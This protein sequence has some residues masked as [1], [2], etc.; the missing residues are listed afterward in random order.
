[1]LFS[2][3][4]L[5]LV[6][7][8]LVSLTLAAEPAM[9]KAKYTIKCGHSGAPDSELEYGY[10]TFQKVLE[11]KSGGQIKVNLFGSEV[12]GNGRVMGES[13]QRGTL[14]MAQVA[15]AVMPAF[16]KGCSV[17]SLPY[18]IKTDKMDKFHK[19]LF[20]GGKIRAYLEKEVEK[21]G[22]K[23]IWC[24]DTPIRSFGATK[25]LPNVEA[26]RGL[27]LRVP[28]SPIE[29]AAAKALG[30]IP[31]TMPYGETYTGMQQGTVDGELIAIGS[32]RP[33]NRGEVEK[34]LLLTEHSYNFQFEVMNKK[35]FDSFPA[36]IQKM[37]LEAG[38]AAEL[39]LVPYLENYQQR[40]EDYCKT[41]GVTVTRLSENDKA[42]MAKAAAKGYEEMKGTYDENL[43]KM[44][45]EIMN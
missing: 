3:K 15:V 12:L 9:A 33:T 40:G 29:I 38:H 21:I 11:E 13:C 18:L 23:L 31:S 6:L 5:S 28:N 37:I 4:T 30:V 14:D 16:W 36:D 17:F 32:M 10:L 26:L 34:H 39:S 35:L 24:G 45:Q 22:F 8:G 41:A 43:L 25:P 19:E 1:M 27:K 44:I 20:A 7:A 42:L 2:K